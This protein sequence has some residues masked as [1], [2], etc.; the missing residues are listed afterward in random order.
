MELRK[1]GKRVMCKLRK[2]ERN[3]ERGIERGGLVIVER[4]A[5]RD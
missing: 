3:A 1:E 5:F 4:S 2:E